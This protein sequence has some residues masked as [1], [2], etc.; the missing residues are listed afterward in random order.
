MLI[1]ILD[2]KTNIFLR[3]TVRIIVVSFFP[4]EQPVSE[5]CSDSNSDAEPIVIWHKNKHE[6]IAENYLDHVQERLIKMHSGEQ[7]LTETTNAI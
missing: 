2:I 3:T 4:R 1:K 5:S 7:Q 6:K